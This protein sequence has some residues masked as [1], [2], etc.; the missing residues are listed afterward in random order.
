MDLKLQKSSAKK[1]N[2]TKK[3]NVDDLFGFSNTSSHSKYTNSD[4]N[5]K[6]YGDKKEDS[7]IIGLVN[8]I[9]V[10]A[11]GK[12]ASDIHIE[13]DEE[14]VNIRFRIDGSFIDYKS[15]PDKLRS[16]IIARIKI[17]AYLRID[18]QRLPQD[19]KI[20]YKLFGGRS[21]DMRISTIPTIYGEKCVVRLLKKD[22]KPPELKD[23]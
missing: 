10:H 19:G 6:T 9:F 22:E 23:L 13:S 14:Q 4:L 2:S 18:E 3:N 1:V 20:A 21:I 16:P 7:F 12:K 8:D 11:I 5:I 17:M 15:F